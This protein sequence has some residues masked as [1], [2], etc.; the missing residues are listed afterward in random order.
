LEEMLADRRNLS[1]LLAQAPFIAILTVLLFTQDPFARGQHASP[2]E[3]I[4]LQ[5]APTLLFLLALT[6][7]WCGTNNSAREIVKETRMFRRE[8]MAG[9]AIFPYFASKL[10]VLGALTA[11]QAAVLWGIVGAGIDFHVA[12]QNQVNLLVWMIASSWCAMGLGLLVSCLARSSD[13]AGSVLPIL[14]VPQVLLGGLLIPIEEMGS[15][16]ALAAASP[17]RWSFSGMSSVVDLTGR[18]TDAGL[19]SQIL[20]A[21][22]TPSSESIAGLAVLSITFVF[23]AAMALRYNERLRA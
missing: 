7:I 6:C 23:T 14:L 13:Q 5:S 2:T 19:D 21:F 9:L 10:A 8:R 16:G 22:R 11:V 17:S 18:F 3:K 4:P 12:P 15:V 1:L 20:E